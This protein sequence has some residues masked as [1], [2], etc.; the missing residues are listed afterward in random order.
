MAERTGIEWCDATWNPWLGC[1]AVSAACDHCYAETW[2]RRTGH[3]ELWAGERRRTSAAYWQQPLRWERAAV[4]DGRRRRVFPSLC[5]P[6]DNQVPARW[7]DDFWH[8]IEQ[9]PH[10]DWCLLTKR[11]QNIAAMLPDPRTGTRPWGEGWPNV[12]LGIT[13]EDQAEFG[14]RWPHLAA[15]PAALRWL[16][17]EP[18]LGPLEL[19]EALAVER[20]R[21]SI[22]W[23]WTE[24]TG[25][26]PRLDWVI[27][28][29]E[30]GPGARPMHPDW[31]RSVRDQCNAAG[32][33]FFFKQW[34][35]W[36]PGERIK[37]A[38]LA[39]DATPG[40]IEPCNDR[41]AFAGLGARRM[42]ILHRVGK[43]AAGRLLDG[44]EWL[45]TPADA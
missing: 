45:E 44:R 36:A 15:V 7:R 13:G 43:R 39:H 30:S 17:Y 2:A 21:L 5:D 4:A 22:G 31:A 33:P 16:S 32:V 20:I 23:H 25:E 10:L 27:C 38:E 40:M 28:G 26:I 1:T 3:P 41:A 12:W 19:G 34:G 14:R 35:D 9:T 29:G 18:A 8:R 11:P 37:V 42:Q 6:F 24:R